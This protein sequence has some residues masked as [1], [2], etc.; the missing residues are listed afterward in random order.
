M[1]ANTADFTNKSFALDLGNIRSSLVRME[2]SIIFSLIERA[3][4]HVNCSV[5]SPDSPDLGA[6]RVHQLKAAGSNGCFADWF[7]Y[8]TECLQAQARRY[9][10]P[11]EYSFFSPLP[12]P[13]MEFNRKRSFSETETDVLAP[14]PQE[15][16]INKK[17]LDVYR[18]KIVP[19]F[20][21]AGEDK[22]IGS[23]AVQDAHCLQ[24]MS[25]RIYFGLFVAESKFQS[26][27]ERAT[28][29]IKA[30]DVD[31]LMRFIT[32]EDVEKR[33]IERVILKTRTFAQNIT[34]A[35]SEA[36]GNTTYK[37]DAEKV[38]DVFR[39]YLMP[40]TKDVEVAYLL[41]RLA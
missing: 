33:N 26:E 31:G 23:T 5:Y 37:V 6:F 36:P 16:L 8:Q 18:T 25:T 15:A 22:D 17:L 30:R 24:L 13:I 41:A 1:A 2:D 10:H 28:A 3:Q 9:Q 38:G 19:A 12:E 11:T 20:C 14:V 27:K 39:D 35:H 29:L 7:L 21:E 40:L 4:Y 34:S 32:K